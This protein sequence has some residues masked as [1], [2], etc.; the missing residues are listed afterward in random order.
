LK[1][2]VIVSFI[3]FI[4]SHAIAQ[5]NNADA[6]G[7]ATPAGHEVS[8]SV[9][10]YKYVEPSPTDISIHGPKFGGG[11][12]GTLSISEAQRWFL[13][14][15]ARGLFGNTTYDGWCSPFL[16]RPD[17]RSPNG[18][19]LGF[20]DRSPCS[21]SGDQDWYLEGR[22]FVGKDFIGRQWGWSPEIGL[23]VRHLSNGTG[24]FAGHRT[25]DYLYLPVGLTA[26]TVVASHHALSFNVEYDYLLHGWQKTRDS[27]FGGGTVP[28][29]STAPAFTIEG[30]SD[31]SFDQHSGWA[32]RASARYQMTRR[33]SVEPEYTHWNVGASTVNDVTATFTVNGI[34]ARQQIGFYEPLN[35]TDEFVVML[36]FR[37]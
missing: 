23:G 8:F 37:F 25:D 30:F 1:R 36:G 16:I 20:G 6:G 33:W 29:T 15:Q 2:L 21:E 10:G 32:L 14:A 22:A 27:Q 28:A 35:T 13:N 19:A 12:T 5:T 18:Y 26:R 17:N 9:G 11:Y 34:T 24:G 4:P 3:A 31:V 7:L